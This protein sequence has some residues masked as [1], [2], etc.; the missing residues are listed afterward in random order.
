[1]GH[2]GGMLTAAE[3]KAIRT[4]YEEAIANAEAE[5]ATALRAAIATG[6]TQKDVVDA[7]G[8]TRETVRRITKPEAGE[9]V[10]SARRRTKVEETNA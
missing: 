6:C 4:R 1:M 5:R 3:L 7:T 10:R 2:H 9:A 8:Y